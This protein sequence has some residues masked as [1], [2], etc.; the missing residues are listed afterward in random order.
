MGGAF[1]ATASLMLRKSF[2]DELPSWLSSAPVLD[3]FLIGLGSLRDGLVFLPQEM[4]VYRVMAENSWSRT[5]NYSYVTSE[6][7]LSY[8]LT[9]ENYLGSLPTQY[10][11]DI[12]RMQSSA[13]LSGAISSIRVRPCGRLSQ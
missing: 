9:Y 6:R 10:R 2:V 5:S 11:N 4:C 8:Q 7:L 1:C 13:L 12:S 3:T